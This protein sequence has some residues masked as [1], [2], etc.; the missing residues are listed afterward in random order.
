[1]KVKIAYTVELDDI[2]KEVSS[3]MLKAVEET[4]EAAEISRRIKGLLSVGTITI[5]EAR[6]D[7]DLARRK[8]EKADTVFSDCEL[9]LEG[10]QNAIEKIKESENEIQDG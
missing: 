2:P 3:M 7:L 8:L 4:E 9:I 1:M 10:Y 5:L 6:K